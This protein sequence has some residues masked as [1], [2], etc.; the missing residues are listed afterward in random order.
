MWSPFSSLKLTIC[1]VHQNVHSVQS[2]KK[3]SDT[4]GAQ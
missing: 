3:L 2:H 1:E 4:A